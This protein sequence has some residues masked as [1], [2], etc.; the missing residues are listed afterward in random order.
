MSSAIFAKLNFAGKPQRKM[1]SAIFAK[2]D[3][4]EDWIEV[5]GVDKE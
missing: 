4:A 1:S 5:V 2:L 3:L